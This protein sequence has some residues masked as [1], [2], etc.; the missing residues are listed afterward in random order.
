MSGNL[1]NGKVITRQGWEWGWTLLPNP[2]D[3]FSSYLLGFFATVDRDLLKL[4]SRSEGAGFVVWETLS[5]LFGTAA[6][7]AQCGHLEV[8]GRLPTRLFIL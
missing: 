6:N 5:V 1:K 7:D 8:L 2:K 3:I 4:L